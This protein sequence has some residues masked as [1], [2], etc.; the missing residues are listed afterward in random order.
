MDTAR[1]TAR[2]IA[3]ANQKGGVGKT[4]TAINLSASVASRGHR[5]LLVDFDP[6]GNASSGVGYPKSRVELSVYDALTGEVAMRDCVRPTEITTLFVV[7]ATM[8]LVGAELEL[9]T[10]EGR[11]R[12]LADA[13]ADVAASYDYIVIDC[14]PS[15]G[16]LTLNA[17][18]AS[19]GVVVPMQAEYFALEGLS[20]LMATIAKVREVYNPKLQIEGV[21]FCMYDPRTNLSGQVRGEVTDHLGSKVFDTAIPRNVR[22]SESPSH[23]KPVMLYDLRCPGSKSYLALAEEFLSRLASPSSAPLAPPAVAGAD[24]AA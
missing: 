4:T 15:L 8:D 16:L 24:S 20:A 17:L 11:E 13:L 10:A 21:L 2:V 7:P 6:Q 22:L 5:V 1:H 3:V 19:D 14:P 9:I 12:V 23:G 18:V